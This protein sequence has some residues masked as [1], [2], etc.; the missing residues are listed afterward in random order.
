MT[1]NDN[2]EY[3]VVL[4]TLPDAAAARALVRGLVEARLAACGTIVP[5]VSSVYWWEGRINEATE[6]Q[7]VLKTR[8]DRWDELV[9]AIRERHPYDVPELLA[10]PVERGLPAYL[11]WIANETSGGTAP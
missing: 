1:R 5:S 9:V 11:T 2:G 7:V 8:R 10:L 4:T 6:T 3:V